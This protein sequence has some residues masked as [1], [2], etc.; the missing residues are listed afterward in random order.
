VEPAIESRPFAD[1]VSARLLQGFQDEIAELYPGWTPNSGPSA[2]P[3][4]FA[5]PGGDFIVARLEGSPAGCAG[6]KRLDAR[7]AEVKRLYVDPGAR[8]RGVAT[9]LMAAL[10]E[11]ARQL[12]YEC[13]RLDTGAAQ[14]GALALFRSLGYRDIAD[15]NGNPWAAYWLEKRLRS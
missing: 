5:P 1:D 12:G 11:R 6:L 10:E 14:P 7:G 9:R 15:Y 3:S 13:L 4:D 2:D 8:G